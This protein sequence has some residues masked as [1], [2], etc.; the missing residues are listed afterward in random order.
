MSA[1]LY[2]DGKIVDMGTDKIGITL[3]VNDLFELKDRQANRSN[4]FSVP[5]TDNN[6]TIYGNIETVNSATDKPYKKLSAK[7]LEDGVEIIQNG[8]CKFEE[9]GDNYKQTIYS[10]IVDF[11][12]QLDGLEMSDLDLSDL[13]HD[14]T[15]AN[16]ISS[17]SNTEGYIYPLA[18]WSDDGAGGV[19]TNANR[20][21]YTSSL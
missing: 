20:H 12:S 13:D 8:Y 18:D 1:E 9:A 16:I 14:W 5:M 21:V 2:I 6:K 10:G 3:Q 17:R 7:Y 15:T 11:F 19:I 4:Q